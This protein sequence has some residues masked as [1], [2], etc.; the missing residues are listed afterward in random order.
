MVLRCDCVRAIAFVVPPIGAQSTGVPAGP[1]ANRE[2]LKASQCD[3]PCSDRST[4]QRFA[5]A[6]VL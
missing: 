5:F 6:E 3:A 4:W 1:R 2:C